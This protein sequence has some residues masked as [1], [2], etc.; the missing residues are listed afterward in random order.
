MT[1]LYI[2]SDIIQ[3]WR[4]TKN[5]WQLAKCLC[6]TICVILNFCW[7]FVKIVFKLNIL[8]FNVLAAYKETYTTSY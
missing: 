7:N 6:L 3:F 2:I 1:I 5:L 4:I 8:T